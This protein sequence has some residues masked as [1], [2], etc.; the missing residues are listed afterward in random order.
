[1]KRRV[2]EIGAVSQLA[3]EATVVR[4]QHL[5]DDHRCKDRLTRR[6]VAKATQDLLGDK[7][8]SLNTTRHIVDFT[9]RI[10]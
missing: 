6:N 9:E 4:A 7:R 2:K 8:R 3:G 10:V 1:M 5:R